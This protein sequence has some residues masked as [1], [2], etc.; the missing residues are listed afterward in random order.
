MKSYH[1]RKVWE[2]VRNLFACP[3]RQ[4]QY[5]SS[6]RGLRGKEV[7]CFQTLRPFFVCGSTRT[8]EISSRWKTSTNCNEGSQTLDYVWW[9]WAWSTHFGLFRKKSSLGVE[10]FSGALILPFI[11]QP[12][13]D[14]PGLHRSFCQSSRFWQNLKVLHNNYQAHIWDC[15]GV[16]TGSTL[17]GGRGTQILPL[18]E[19][20]AASTVCPYSNR[21]LP[22]FCHNLKGET[23]VSLVQT[24]FS[25]ILIIRINNN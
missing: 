4:R 11:G 23:K 25:S 5:P 13:F 21:V 2:A 22:R 8:G 14:G 17:F 12:D 20:G 7:S 1:V 18:F 3:T 15:S 24:L 6:L 19:W 9:G 10:D 16:I